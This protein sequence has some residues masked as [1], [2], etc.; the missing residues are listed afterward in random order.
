MGRD[1]SYRKA[2]WCEPLPPS[3]QRQCSR[4]ASR[5]TCGYG[6]ADVGLIA[7]EFARGMLLDED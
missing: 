3:R 7:Y 2:S 1:S 4:T 5:S 6:T